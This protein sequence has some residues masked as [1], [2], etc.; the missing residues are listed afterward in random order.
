MLATVQSC[1]CNAKRGSSVVILAGPPRELV[2]S[3]AL[4]PNA[5]TIVLA[6][7]LCR[8]YAELIRWRVR[9]ILASAL[10]E[11]GGELDAVI[12]NRVMREVMMVDLANRGAPFSASAATK[13]PQR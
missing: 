12:A 7:G 9:V 8:I 4:A 11:V 10:R 1:C 5:Q 2:A 6:Q 3:I 13:Q